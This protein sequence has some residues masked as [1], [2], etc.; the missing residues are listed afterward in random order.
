[1]QRPQLGES[2][3]F[4]F[5]A[6]ASRAERPIVVETR[7]CGREK[8]HDILTQACAVSAPLELAPADGGSTRMVSPRTKKF[9]LLA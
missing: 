8:R 5:G 7:H 2:G 9:A 3:P 1:M 6:Y 4:A